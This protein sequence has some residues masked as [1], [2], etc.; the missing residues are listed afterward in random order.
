MFSNVLIV[1]TPRAPAAAGSLPLSCPFFTEPNILGTFITCPTAERPKV[2]RF[3]AVGALAFYSWLL[4]FIFREIEMRR[5]LKVKLSYCVA[6]LCLRCESRF[7]QK[8]VEWCVV[9]IGFSLYFCNRRPSRYSDLF[10]SL[11]ETLLYPQTKCFVS[12]KCHRL[13]LGRSLVKV[14]KRVRALTGH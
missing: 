12:V 2:S 3:L 9:V 14:S 5:C 13:I 1:P 7:S 10:F 11:A 4:I 6:P 8:H